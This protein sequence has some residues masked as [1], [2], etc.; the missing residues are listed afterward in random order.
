MFPSNSVH[1]DY[2]SFVENDTFI[3][4]EFHKYVHKP[5]ENFCFLLQPPNLP[6]TILVSMHTLYGENFVFAWPSQFCV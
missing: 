1:F 2:R 4:E 6:N 3:E 5:L